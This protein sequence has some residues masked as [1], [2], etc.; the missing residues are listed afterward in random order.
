MKNA[1]I[2]AIKDKETLEPKFL[3]IPIHTDIAQI[4]QRFWR[5]YIFETKQ[6]AN[7]VRHDWYKT[8]EEKKKTLIL[9]Q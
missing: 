4:M 9:N 8:Y 6:K 2:I 1:Y 5:A 3:Q 7:E